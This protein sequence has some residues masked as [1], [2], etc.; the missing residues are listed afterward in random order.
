MEPDDNGER[1]SGKEW[2]EVV[3][4]FFAVPAIL[5]FGFLMLEMFAYALGMFVVFG[6]LLFAPG[7]KQAFHLLPPLT[8]G[9]IISSPLVLSL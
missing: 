5:I 7:I 9:L 4:G 1:G 3:N 6:S 8:R 2:Q